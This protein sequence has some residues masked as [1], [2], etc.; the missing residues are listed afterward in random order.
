MGVRRTVPVALNV[1]SDDGA[2]LE[3]TVDAFFRSAQYVVD[4]TFQG[5]CV[6]NSKS[7]LDET[8]NDVPEA[9]DGFNGSLVQAARNKAAEACKSVLAR[10]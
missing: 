10:G 2:L 7:T 4:H 3:E 8:Y 5:G 6:T 1:D 9:T